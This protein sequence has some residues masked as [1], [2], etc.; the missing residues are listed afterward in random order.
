[1]NGTVSRRDAIKAT[2]VFSSAVLAGSWPGSARGR[3]A[4]S[5]F[6]DEGIHLLAL[7]DFGT[8]N[9][10]Q[11]LVARRMNEFAGTLGAPLTAVLALGDNFYNH[12]EMERFG[13]GFEEMYSKEH[14][15]CPFYAC[16]GN[17]D[18]GPGYDSKQGPAKADMQLEYALR[19]PGSRWKMPAK[20]YSVE[21]PS[22]GKPLVKLIYLDSNFFEGALTPQEKIDQKRWLD[23]ELKKE[24][25]AK[26]T[27]VVAHHPVFTDDTK[28]QD[29]RRLIT[30]WGPHFQAN[31]ISLY[32]SGHDHSLQHLQVEGYQPSFLVSGGGGA[33]LYETTK[34]ARGFSQAVLGFNH[35]HVNEERIA[36]QLI[37]AE[38]NCL[39]SFERDLEGKVNVK[40]A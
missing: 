28:R 13:R 9:R 2:L 23:A 18:Y 22:G 14:L 10:S 6:G 12:L 35:I 21:L 27:W 16:L 31:P 38:G 36:V 5:R 3:Q 15:D 7:G 30:D 37:D 1:M 29:S 32:L 25:K 40:T 4:E 39:H 34:S 26:W 19:N 11:E 17:H 20:W 24:T 8:A 33:K